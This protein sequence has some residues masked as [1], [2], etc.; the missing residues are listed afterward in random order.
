MQEVSNHPVHMYDREGKLSPSA[1]IPFCAFGRNM[2]SMG[3]MKDNFEVPICNSFQAR[4]LKHRICY[5]VDLQKYKR[6]NMEQALRLGL[7]FFMDY[8]ED[9]QSIFHEKIRVKA[10]GFKKIARHNSENNANIHINTIG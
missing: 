5:E 10:D 7:V 1:F 2:S 6:N 8:N 3:Y 4:V 9:R